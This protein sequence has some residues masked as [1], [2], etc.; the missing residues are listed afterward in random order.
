VSLSESGLGLAVAV[1]ALA[2][3]AVLALPGRLRPLA[4]GGGTALVGA[5]GVTA[6][7]AAL[8]G[9][10]SPRATEPKTA[11]SAMPYFRHNSARRPL[12]ALISSK[13]TASPP[14]AADCTPLVSTRSR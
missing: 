12:S 4:A 6:G 3:L 11:S 1:A 8:S 5:A 13:F 2:A 14:S 9:P 7:I 10:A